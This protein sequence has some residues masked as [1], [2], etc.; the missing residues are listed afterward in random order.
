MVWF[1][2]TFHL[3]NSSIS[4][5]LFAFWK[6]LNA[7]FILSWGR[8]SR[9]TK[10][11][12]NW[13]TPHDHSDFRTQLNTTQSRS[14][15]SCKIS[16]NHHTASR[17]LCDEVIETLGWVIAVPKVKGKQAANY[18]TRITHILHEV[19]TLPVSLDERQTHALS[20]AIPPDGWSNCTSNSIQNRKPELTN[21][22]VSR[23][24][25]WSDFRTLYD[26]YRTNWLTYLPTQVKHMQINLS[27]RSQ[28]WHLFTTF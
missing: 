21:E 9:F 18:R 14:T 27:R 19:P 17:L 4:F 1:N 13:L 23:T 10:K 5:N 25:H 28:S 15:F 16:P 24:S 11:R 22:F 26:S 7:T 20:W 2:I 3:R 12:W 6:S 8:N